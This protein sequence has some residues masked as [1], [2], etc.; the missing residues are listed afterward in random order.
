MGK[1]ILV[2]LTS[3]NKI[4]D[5]GK[6]TGWYLPELAHPYKDLVGAGFEMDSVSPKGGK[7]PI[8][9]LVPVR[10]NGEPIVKGRKLTSFSNAEEDSMQLSSLMPFMLET[11]LKEQGAQYTAA[12]PWQKHVVVDGKLVTGQNPNSAAGV[13]QAIIQLLK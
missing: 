10:I 5:S 7:T 2:I 11:R 9:S 4:G 8:V 3:A 12:T 13:G 6:P 1:K